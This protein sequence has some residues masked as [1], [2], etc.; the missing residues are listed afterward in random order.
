MTLTNLQAAKTQPANHDDAASRDSCTLFTLSKSQ[1]H[2][3]SPSTTHHTVFGHTV[4]CRFSKPGFL[5]SF[6]ILQKIL[7]TLSFFKLPTPQ[8]VCAH[9]GLQ[10]LQAWIQVLLLH[11][12]NPNNIVIL[13]TPHTTQFWGTQW[14]VDSPSLD[15]CTLFTFYKSC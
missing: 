10:I 12:A 5:Y 13:Q 15:S 14:P 4:A 8:S 3:H 2:C 11:F 9:R 1:S 7:L 6:H